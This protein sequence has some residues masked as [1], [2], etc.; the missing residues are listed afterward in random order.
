LIQNNIKQVFDIGRGETAPITGIGFFKSPNTNCY[1]I[2]IAT[3]D[4][5]YKF[6]ETL[7][8]QDNRYPPLQTVF[9]NYLNIPEE[10]RDYEEM[11][12]KLSYSQLE[13]IMENK[14]PRAFGWLTENGVFFGEISHESANSPNF[15]TTKKTLTYPEQMDDYRTASYVSKN[16]SNAPI[17]MILTDFHLL[18]QYS[19]HITGISLINHEVIYDEY[20]ADQ[21]GKLMC[22]VKDEKNGNIYTFSNKTIFRYKVR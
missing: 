15:I 14:F 6:H 9:T 22:V 3:I 19:D 5:L 11:P 1:I 12:S 7:Y 21:H 20:F 18:I 2:L 4:R 17:S 8:A 10:V 13:F 16:F